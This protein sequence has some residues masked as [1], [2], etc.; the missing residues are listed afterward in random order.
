MFQTLWN[1]EE[2][3]NSRDE[4]RTVFSTFRKGEMTK[5]YWR[6]GKLDYLLSKTIND[7]QIVGFNIGKTYRV[8]EMFCHSFF[9]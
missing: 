5:H 8:F 3:E 9:I 1:L 6:T 4:Q 7:I 2:C